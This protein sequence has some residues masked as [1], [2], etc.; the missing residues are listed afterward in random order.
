MIGGFIILTRREF[1]KH[2]WRIIGWILIF[3]QLNSYAGFSS[4]YLL[5]NQLGLEFLKENNIFIN[6][7]MKSTF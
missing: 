4:Q 1:R 6:F 5:K 2:P 3:E 7:W